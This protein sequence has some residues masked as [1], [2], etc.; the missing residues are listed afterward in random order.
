MLAHFL[1]GVGASPVLFLG[2]TFLDESVK[3]KVAP[4]YIAIFQSLVICGPAV[5][6]TVGGQLL[7]IYTDNVPNLDI[8]PASSLW[9]GAWWPGFL[10]CAAMAWVCVLPMLCFP[11]NLKENKQSDQDVTK[12]KASVISITSMPAKKLPK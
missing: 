11:A 1:H 8:T 9:V 5:G 12:R 4:L 6:Y 3:A 7:N 2:I 10:I